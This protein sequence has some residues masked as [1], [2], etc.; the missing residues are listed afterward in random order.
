M[1]ETCPCREI[2]LET[3]KPE[4]KYLASVILEGIGNAATG[5]LEKVKGDDWTTLYSGE[6]LC[7]LNSNLGRTRI[8][9]ACNSSVEQIRYKAVKFLSNLSGRTVTRTL[10]AKV[11]DP[12]DRISIEAIKGLMG[13]GD[14]YAKR[15]HVSGFDLIAV[16]GVDAGL[17]VNSTGRPIIAV[18]GKAMPLQGTVELRLDGIG[19][20]S[21]DSA[22]VGIITSLGPVAETITVKATIYDI[23][24]AL[25]RH[26]PS[27]ET[28]K[29]VIAALEDADNLP[30]KV[31]WIE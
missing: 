20:G 12:S 4:D 16:P 29:K 13:R 30:Y 11:L 5:Y 22:H 24:A 19:I 27:F 15:T 17:I 7:Y 18:T 9:A 21:T 10:R 3:G 28:V 1:G 26:N 8:I 23:L 6:A 14:E 31:T 25:A 2:S